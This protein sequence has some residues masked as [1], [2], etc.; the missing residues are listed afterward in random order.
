VQERSETRA[1]AQ[2]A[3][4]RVKVGC[5]DWLR[6]GVPGNCTLEA[7][8]I[9][10]PKRRWRRSL[11]RCGDQLNLQDRKRRTVRS[12]FTR[13]TLCLRLPHK[14]LSSRSTAN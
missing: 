9:E 7:V 14:K 12:K 11:A 10:P 13:Q 5:E 4:L 2:Q 6:H 8:E 1:A 3:A